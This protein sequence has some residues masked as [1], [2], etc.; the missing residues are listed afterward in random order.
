MFVYNLKT[1]LYIHN[2]LTSLYPIKILVIVDISN[3]TKIEVLEVL[4]YMF[5]VSYYY[6]SIDCGKGF[7]CAQHVIINHIT[8]INMIAIPDV[9]TAVI[10]LLL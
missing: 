3:I 4:Q 6:L 8:V 9:L 2:E 7:S 10:V 1:I 5:T